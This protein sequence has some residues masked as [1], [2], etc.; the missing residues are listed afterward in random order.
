M[1]HPSEVY[2]IVVARRL[3]SPRVR[4]KDVNI[5]LKA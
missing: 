2:P 1:L 5:P 4:Y 3:G